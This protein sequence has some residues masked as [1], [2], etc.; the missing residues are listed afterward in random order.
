M[1]KNKGMV[2]KSYRPL[3]GSG[4]DVRFGEPVKQ[5]NEYMRHGRLILKVY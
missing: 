5:T 2:K 3:Q 1:F 4:M